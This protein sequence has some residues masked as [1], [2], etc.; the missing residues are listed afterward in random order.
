LQRR[1]WF[2]VGSKG[3]RGRKLYFIPGVG[4]DTRR[5][6]ASLVYRVHHIC[7]RKRRELA[8][9]KTL[10]W[11]KTIA[12]TRPASEATRSRRR[13]PRF[14]GIRRL[15]AQAYLHLHL[16]QSLFKLLVLHPQF[17]NSIIALFKFFQNEADL[18]TSVKCAIYGQSCPR[19]SD[20]RGVRRYT[21]ALAPR[22]LP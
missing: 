22:V 19:W 3:N 15:L 21:S 1:R 7:K 8:L 12:R 17:T 10:T 16:L 9:E 2:F 6:I 20:F 11:Q 18:A 5:S 4:F 13:R 14:W